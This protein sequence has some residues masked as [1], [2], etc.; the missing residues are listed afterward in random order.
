MTDGKLRIVCVSDTHE[1][2]NWEAKVPPGDIL[3]HAGDF[4][5]TGRLFEVESFR[6]RILSLPHRHKIVVAGN[7]ELTFDSSLFTEKLAELKERFPSLKK[8]DWSSIKSL[9]SDE[10]EL[11][12]LENSGVE[13]AGLFFWGSP[14][15]PKFHFWGFQ[16]GREKM[17]EIW[18]QIPSTTDV[19]ITHGPPFGILDGSEAKRSGCEALKLAVSEKVRPG[20]HIFGHVHSGRG[21]VRMGETLFVNAAICDDAYNPE[22]PAIVVEVDLETKAFSVVGQ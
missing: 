5:M 9:I 11:T 2:E 10:K 13:V 19:L 6:K 17:H 20:L 14:Y 16:K 3:I 1:T 21:H 7:H 15:Q 12:Y 22:N 18:D 4:S 8:A